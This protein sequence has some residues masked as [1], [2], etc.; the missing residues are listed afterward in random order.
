[1]GGGADVTVAVEPVR[2]AFLEHARAEAE[3][4]LH[5]ADEQA[6]ALL[7]QA[8][9]QGLSLVE[10]ARAEG[11]AVA[12]TE[13]AAEEA[14]ARR[15]ARALVLAAEQELLEEL[16]AGAHEAAHRL[17][18]APGYAELVD[19]LAATAT[20]QLGGEARVESDPPEAGGVR[21]SSGH[22][23]VDYSLDVLADR[24]LERLGSRLERL[25]A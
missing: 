6:A 8:E 19:R 15:R 17:R 20:T 24:C 18:Q 3:R 9:A 16:R 11:V 7:R 2:A 4:T 21:A 12:G 1:V 23:H 22:R 25:W 10:Q 5:E 13:G 14:R